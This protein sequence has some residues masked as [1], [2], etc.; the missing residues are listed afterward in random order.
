M[1][2]NAA[3]RDRGTHR[4]GGQTSG[5]KSVITPST[6]MDQ[7]G[8]FFIR[9]GTIGCSTFGFNAVISAR[10]ERENYVDNRLSYAFT[11]SPMIL[12]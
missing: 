4:G 9:V 5:S 2:A 11:D 8:E 7:S 3:A 10:H 6:N 1:E 12:P